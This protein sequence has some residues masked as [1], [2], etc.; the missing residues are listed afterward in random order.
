VYQPDSSAKSFVFREDLQVERVE[1]LALMTFD[2]TAYLVL[3][4]SA[5][6]NG[7]G[8]ALR[9]CFQVFRAQVGSSRPRKT[10]GSLPELE[11][12]IH[13]AV[14]QNRLVRKTSNSKS[15]ARQKRGSLP[16]I[17]LDNCERMT[18]KATVQ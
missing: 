3:R 9:L 15:C 6:P 4:H 5:L 16:E 14:M 12:V 17:L 2:R 18:Y 11:V 10:G 13:E 7:C 1:R 8:T